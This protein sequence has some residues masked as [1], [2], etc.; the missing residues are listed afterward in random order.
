MIILHQS[1]KDAHFLHREEGNGDIKLTLAEEVTFLNKAAILLALDSLEADSSVILDV[2]NTRFMD[3][4]IIEI[5]SELISK[6]K[7]FVGVRP[8]ADMMPN[9]LARVEP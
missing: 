2:R 6:Q 1:F 9:P 7:I 3:Q 5:L 8:P 4:D